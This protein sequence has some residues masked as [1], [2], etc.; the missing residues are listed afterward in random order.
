MVLLSLTFSIRFRD[1]ND[2]KAATQGDR[3]A[4]DGDPG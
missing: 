1:A 2:D 3:D 4:D